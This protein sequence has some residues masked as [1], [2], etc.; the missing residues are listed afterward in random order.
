LIR[1]KKS[2]GNSGY[3]ATKQQG[4]VDKRQQN[5]REEWIR[6]NKTTGKNCDFSTTL[7]VTV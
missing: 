7:F 6:G 5:N 2:I 3:E 1:F 4:R